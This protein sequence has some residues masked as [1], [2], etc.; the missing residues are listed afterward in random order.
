MI[1]VQF[2][3]FGRGK[4]VMR[5]NQ[6]VGS[7]SGVATLGAHRRS[8]MHRRHRVGGAC[9]YQRRGAWRISWNL[10]RNAQ[11]NARPV[12]RRVRQREIAGNAGGKRQRTQDE[13]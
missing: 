8:A 3:A 11:D 12:I 2:W 9:G 7:G 4:A 13:R 10:R 6:S 1:E 5:L